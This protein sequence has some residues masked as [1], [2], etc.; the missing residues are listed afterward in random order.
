M[1]AGF[2]DSDERHANNKKS[3]LEGA[4]EKI[5]VIDHSKFGN[6]SFAKIGDLRD[7]TTIVTDE[8]PGE[9]WL[10]EFAKFNVECIYPE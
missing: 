7:L 6:S 5:L 3:M 9:E 1:R 10:E 2:T 4:K 8:K